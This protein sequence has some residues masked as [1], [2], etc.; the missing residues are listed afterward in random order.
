MKK[1]IIIFFIFLTP[2]VFGQAPSIEWQKTLGGSNAD[3]PKSVIQYNSKYIITGFSNSQIS[4]DKTVTNGNTN[5]NDIWAIG[6]NDSGFILWQKAYLHSLVSSNSLHSPDV[7]FHFFDSN[8]YLGVTEL[9]WDVDLA[10][11][12]SF[13]ENGE[14]HSQFGP[15]G[16][17]YC[18][19]FNISTNQDIDFNDFFK[20]SNNNY[21]FTGTKF[22][23][24]FNCNNT[25]PNGGYFI[26]I[27]SSINYDSV[28][29]YKEYSGNLSDRLTSTIQTNDGGFLLSGSSNSNIS[30]DKT[31]NTLGGYDFWIIKTD[32]QGNILW[33]NTIGGNLTDEPISVIQTNDNGFLIAGSSN[34]NVSGDKTENSKGGFDYWLVKLDS[35]GTVQ[36]NKTI[37]GSLDDKLSKITPT[38]DGNYILL[39]SSKSSISGDKN[40]NCRGEFDA[41]LVKIN[42]SGNIL[43][44]KTIGGNLN[45]TAYDIIQ[46]NDFGF[47]ILCSSESS[48]SGEK[49]EISRGNLDYWILKLEPDSLS[50]HDNEFLNQLSIYPNPTNNNVT[51]NYD[52]S[53][54]KASILIYNVL[55]QLITKTN[56]SQISEKQIP[57]EGQ[58]GVY[59]IEIEAENHQKKVFK[60][61]KN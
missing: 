12:H 44:Q 2:I 23:T 1:E 20:I 38:S 46:T 29:W 16:E 15:G 31:E 19:P 36:W 55:G 33:Q 13:D 7:S 6:L 47:L 50:N 54:D 42:T 37:G 43:W 22:N 8:F 48:I 40:E 39:G 56:L 21:L 35:F 60:I 27:S 49:S 17:L 3:I 61:V 45:D 9:D 51:I 30:G 57:I 32:S 24:S 34:S 58:N 41:W 11:I 59:F 18:G 28:I 14:T 52:V 25:W 5:I 26:S 4:G 53:L 10:K